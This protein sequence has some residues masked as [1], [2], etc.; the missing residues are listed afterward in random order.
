MLLLEITNEFKSLM[1]KTLLKDE[2][3]FLKGN[4]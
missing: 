4:P 1:K 2:N 3:L